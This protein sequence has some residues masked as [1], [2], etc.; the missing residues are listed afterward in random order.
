MVRHYGAI[1]PNFK[2]ISWGTFYSF[3]R[4]YRCP[5]YKTHLT[6]VSKS[7]KLPKNQIFNEIMTFPCSCTTGYVNQFYKRHDDEHMRLF[8]M[9]TTLKQIMLPCKNC[10]VLS[11][12]LVSS[13]LYMPSVIRNKKSINQA[14]DTSLVFLI[15]YFLPPQQPPKGPHFNLF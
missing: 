2:F 4:F 5:K 13:C 10:I 3:W 12:W 1:K 8:H 6:L 7:Q 14:R 15:I 9:C 11:D